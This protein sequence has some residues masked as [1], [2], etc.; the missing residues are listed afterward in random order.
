MSSVRSDSLM[1]YIYKCIHTN[2][3]DVHLQINKLYLY[4]KTNL[5]IFL[6]NNRF[7]AVHYELRPSCHWRVF[8]KKI[9]TQPAMWMPCKSY[10]CI[11]SETATPNNNDTKFY[12][13]HNHHTWGW[14]CISVLPEFSVQKFRWPQL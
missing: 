6:C 1:I 7:Q 11:V 5:L 4:S 13:N 14:D 12:Q 8:L 10:D 3:F 9:S 2:I